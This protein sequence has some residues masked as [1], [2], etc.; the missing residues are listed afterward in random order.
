MSK[1]L[2]RSVF[3]NAALLINLGSLFNADND[4]LWQPLT[5][6]GVA[7]ELKLGGGC[8]RHAGNYMDMSNNMAATNFMAPLFVLFLFTISIKKWNECTG[9]GYEPFYLNFQCSYRRKKVSPL[10]MKF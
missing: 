2:S 1:P 7:T 5:P 6:R 4:V 8:S 10:N 9:N 3:V